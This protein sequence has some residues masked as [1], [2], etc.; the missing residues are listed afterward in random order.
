MWLE[1]EETEGGDGEELTW[2]LAGQVRH[3]VMARNPYI[4]APGRHLGL[5][6]MEV[7]FWYV[8]VW[9]AVAKW[10]LGLSPPGHA[11]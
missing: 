2:T 4:Q 6:Q 7:G 3:D 8:S 1:E 11:N 10:V 5:S 9:F